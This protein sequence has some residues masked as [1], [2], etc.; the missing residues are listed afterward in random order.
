MYPFK[1]HAS[2]LVNS[3]LNPGGSKNKYQGNIDICSHDE[4][5]GWICLSRGSSA[6]IVDI[7]IN[8][9]LVAKN[10]RADQYREDVK[11][12]GYGD[13]LCGFSVN[14]ASADLTLRTGSRQVEVRVAGLREVALSHFFPQ[15]ESLKSPTSGALA[16]RA[17]K[18]HTKP[19]PSGPYS[20]W[21][22]EIKAG[23]LSG[24]AVSDVDPGRNFS[25]DVLIDGVPFT[26]TAN[27]KPRE[28]LANLS[29]SM[30]LGGIFLELP[31]DLLEAGEHIISLKLPDGQVCSKSFKAEE[32][33]RPVEYP[34]D[35]F[36]LPQIAVIVPVYN[37]AEDLEVCIDRLQSFTPDGVEILLINDSS[38]D[39]R[40]AHIF[41]QAERLP[42]FR[43]LNNE[44]NLGFSGTINRGLSET[45]RK[46]VVLLNSDAR[47]T[48]GWIDGL[49]RAAYHAPRIA[50]VTPLSDRAGAF[51]A[52]DAGN[53][54][55]LP[56]GIDEISFARCVRRTSRGL[57]PTVPTGN[58]FC[59][60]VRR[61]CIEEIGMLDSE[62][63]PRGYGEENDFCMRAGR[64][65]WRHIIDDRTYVFHDR[66][67]SFGSSKAD[68]M[69]AGREI[70]DARYPEYKTAIQIFSRGTKIALVRH[71]VRKLM[72]PG[73]ALQT[74]RTRILFVISTQT[75]GTPQT[76]RDL[77]GGLEG[78][79]EGWS[80]RC[81]SKMLIL[82]R[83]ENGKDV[84]VREH[85]LSE[86]VDPISHRSS[87]YDAVV[88]SWLFSFDFNLV[89]IRHIA[90][91]S[92][93]LPQL[94]KRFGIPVVFSFHDFYMISPTVKLVDDDGIYQGKVFHSKDNATRQ[95]LWPVGSQPIPSGDWL[96]WWQSRNAEVLAH[97]DAYITTSDSARALILETF[98]AITEERFLVIPH[99]RDFAEFRRLREPY[100]SAGTPIR[101]LVPG[102]IDT[103]KGLD[104][105]VALAEH[106]NE[107]M[108]E[109]HILGNASK[110]GRLFPKQF[111]FHGPYARSEFASKVAPLRPHIAA[112]FS[113][114]DETWCHTLTES[115]SV[116][117]PVAVLDMPTVAKRVRESGAG[118][119][120]DHQDIP[121]LYENIL[122]VATDLQEQE[123][124]DRA[125][126]RWQ[127]GY[128]AAN[129]TR[130]MAAHYL[131][132]YRDLLRDPTTVPGTGTRA[133][134]AV[135]CP[136]GRNLSQAYASTSIRVW[137]RTRNSIARDVSFTRMTPE[138]LLAAVKEGMVDAA[139]IQR[140][141]LPRM[142]VPRVL[143]AMSNAGVPFI[144]DIDDDLLNVPVEKD[145]QG[146]YSSYR[147]AL[148][149]L[150][151]KAAV[152]T[153]TTDVLAKK[154]KAP[155]RQLEVL[156]NRLSNR[157]W[158]Y[159]PLPRVVDDMIRALYMG[160]ATHDED[161]ALI[162][163][164]LEQI[165]AS[166]PTFRLML[167]GVSTD[168][169]V[170]AGRERW[171][172][173]IE[174]PLE[175]KN[176]DIFVGWLRSQAARADFG[177][178]P[179]TDATF[180]LCK[181]PLKV[182]DYAALGLPILASNHPVYQNE[183][184]DAPGL[185]LVDSKSDDWHKA[186]EAKVDAG[187]RTAEISEQQRT[188]VFDQGMI[189][190]EA[191]DFETIVK[192]LL[193]R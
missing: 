131:A 165:A 45:G 116:G 187:R 20:A 161:L 74:A 158:S 109:F 67:K 176:Y 64:L 1:R 111:K 61:E 110:K 148:T 120:L 112:M 59:M 174:V 170:I 184:H 6:A 57:Y 40:I 79:F 35:L 18:I 11:L 15:V 168:A 122:R 30:G 193:V 83:F 154:L 49:F 16:E 105:L 4:V 78:D 129:T 37:A 100:L 8:G 166:S 140:T 150:L 173:R 80:L 180:N 128:G 91:H 145:P 81:T 52:P 94:V 55:L 191:D 73:V 66:S 19:K 12:A 34:A 13:G 119:V 182:L 169:S 142:I 98:P 181:S 3:V 33:I 39:P 103:T 138:T 82:C 70:V 75:G 152:V 137:E 190:G 135:V 62:A 107:G 108:L 14:L 51:S 136:A 76:N 149:Q 93:T 185:T 96:R 56:Q 179:L 127:S 121:T 192:R 48:P 54:N 50:T 26:R 36:G 47:V 156:P 17:A 188:W 97:C 95:S 172:E 151:D 132:V 84:I 77:M 163:P 27:D 124:T 43:I 147:P 134:V 130:T 146:K 31:L 42:N 164:A 58:G 32:K 99:G 88:S 177:L 9:I 183:W 157:L 86:P 155:G 38:T 144:F 186:L 139:V 115:W 71:T 7:F 68:L 53:E 101:I 160:T 63:F 92:L 89:H 22:D 162:M 2:L 44:R 90:W 102:N 118:W 126:I 85:I 143:E 23:H 25:V 159:A 189:Q 24:W 104:L 28:D 65:G 117:L 41:E 106:D 167:I 5:S 10:L 60:Y 141:A 125:I 72:D 171:I 113:I 123:N 114:W 69:A 153:V 21:I 133:H 178:A 29:R 46:D 87:E 175:A